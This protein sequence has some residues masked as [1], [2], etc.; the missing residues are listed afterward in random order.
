MYD[1]VLTSPG[2]DLPSRNGT[3]WGLV[4]GFSHYADLVAGRSRDTALQSAWFGDK[5]ALKA[6]ALKLAVEY[7]QVA[8]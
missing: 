4:N 6:D 8:N 2:S 5:A 3:L 7:A 1:S